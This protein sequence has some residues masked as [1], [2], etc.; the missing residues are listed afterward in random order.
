MFARNKVPVKK[1]PSN[2]ST[3]EVLFKHKTNATVY[4]FDLVDFMILRLFIYLILLIGL[5]GSN[6]L[7]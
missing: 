3:V 6:P 4:R 2:N 7:A 1:S 5:N